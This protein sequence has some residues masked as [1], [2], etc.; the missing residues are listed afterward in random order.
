MIGTVCALR[1]EKGVDT[2]IR[3]FA[4]MQ[5]PNTALVLVGS[6]PEEPK[7]RALAKELAVENCH[8]EAATSEV[9]QWLSATD[10]FV[11]PSRSEALS[12]AL[13]EAM[14]CGCCPMATRV[15]GNPE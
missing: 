1:P 2:L 7:L 9:A 13:M 15:G 14:S 11:L 12:N 8:F 4:K 5:S 6:G 10:I 3:A